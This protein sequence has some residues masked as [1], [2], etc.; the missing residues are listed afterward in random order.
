MVI[1]FSATLLSLPWDT[2]S[3]PLPMLSLVISTHCLKHCTCAVTG[4][5]NIMT[6][7]AYD[8]IN[9]S[10]FIHSHTNTKII[11][12]MQCHP[13]QYPET[14]LVKT[15]HSNIVGHSS[16]VNKCVLKTIFFLT[17]LRCIQCL[18]LLPLVITR[19]QDFPT[20]ILPQSRILLLCLQQVVWKPEPC[21][22][23]LSL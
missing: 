16:L 15:S 23:T 5:Q 11:G 2:M 22:L 1:P 9:G 7:L 8:H 20:K 18:G 21:H 12:S 6:H 3:T 4:V 17:F 13:H 10:F 14:Q 19:T